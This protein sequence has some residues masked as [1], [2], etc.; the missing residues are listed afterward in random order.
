VNAT[1][2]GLTYQWRKGN[3][4]LING[5]NIS[6]A[7]TAMLTINPV[8]LLDAAANYNV[9]IS[10]TCSPNDTSIDVSLTVNPI[11]I[12]VAGSNSPVCIGSSINLTAQTVNGGT[13]NW[14]GP[15]GFNSTSQNP[16]ITLATIADAGN[17]TLIVSANGCIS[18]PS[19]IIVDVII[20]NSDLSVV[21]TVNN[22]TP[23]VGSTIIFT[24]VATN[25]GPQDATGV[26]VTDTIQSGYTFVSSTTTIGIYNQLTSLWT[27]GNMLNGASETLTITAIVNPTGIYSNTV[28][29]TGNQTD[30]DT[31]NNISTVLTIP[32]DFFIP[33]GFSPNADGIND[34]FFIRGLDYYPGNSITIFNRWGD[35]VFDAN[36]YKNDWD[37]TSALGLRV[38]G[39]VLPEGTYFYV[40]DLGNGNPVYKG[41]IY[42]TR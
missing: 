12:A 3:V 39:N 40:L 23:L 38:G 1:G 19:T 30:S 27:I 15:N 26:A 31:L 5:G 16:T 42:L 36:P 32:N 21:K 41:T 33:E 37:G 18:A 11:S 4:N 34:V 7:T 17:Y 35:K 20:C 9:V 29:I 10:S 24:I 6:G 2:S 22:L 8:S 25:N 13:Y 28:T 14:T